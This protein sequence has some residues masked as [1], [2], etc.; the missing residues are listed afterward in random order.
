MGKYKSGVEPYMRDGMSDEF[1][2]SMTA[3]LDD[4]Y[5]PIAEPSR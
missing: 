4:L 2:E 1:R 3:L 5:A